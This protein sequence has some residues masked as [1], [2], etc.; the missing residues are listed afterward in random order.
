[1]KKPY[2]KPVILKLRTGFMNKFGSFAS[3]YRY[4][5]R[6]E[7]DGIP[8]EDLVNQFGSPLFVFS[9]KRL[10]QKFRTVKQAFTLRYPNV[11]FTWSYKT[12]YLDAICAILHSEGE[13]AEVVSE[14]EYEKARRLGVP[15]S[16][17]VYNGPYKSYESLKRAVKEGARINID[18]FEEIL[19]LEKIA[20]EL[21]EKVKAGIRIN[22][23]TGIHPQWTRFGFNL[24]NGQAWNAVKRI[25]S[26]GKI[27]INGLHCHI[28]TFILEPTAYEKEVKKLVEFGY[29]IEE[30]FGFKI[31]YIDIGGGFPS[32]IR[33]KGVYLPPDVVIPSIEDYAEKICDAL[34]KS[35]KPGDYPKLIIESGRAIVDEAG[36][37][38]STVHAIKRLP[39][40]R[41]AYVLD[42][43]INL[44]F[45]SFWYHFTVE[46]DREIHGPAEPCILYGPL[47]MNIDVVDD[48]VYLPPLPRGARLILSPVGAYNVT[49]WM[50][51]ITYRPRV[52]LIGENGEIDVIREKEDLSDIIGRERLPDRLKI[53]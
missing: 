46:V 41:K 27:E 16:E 31:E 30:E 36:F 49:Q 22:M 47:C 53:G 32:K 42:A 17:I 33:L 29:A 48:T 44:L 20:D 21:G 50:Q 15:G 19:D 10:R 4:L 9:E 45:T 18:H 35:L 28:G 26:A 6:K 1:M 25:A 43:G 51:F 23:D 7:I 38:I 39:D 5:V 3:P 37:L 24:E 12:N 13:T 11:E 34:L 14:F 52:V 40:G 8:I 2:E